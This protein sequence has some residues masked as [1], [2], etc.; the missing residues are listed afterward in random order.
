MV[1]NGVNYKRMIKATLKNLKT[2]SFSEGASTISQQLIKNTHLTSEKTLRRKF[3]EL[4]LA[5]ELE[6]SENIITEYINQI[7]MMNS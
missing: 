2:M 3:D 4:I 7:E 5:K 1:H 6:K